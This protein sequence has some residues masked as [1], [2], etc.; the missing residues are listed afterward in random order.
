[1]LYLVSK[2]CSV[3]QHTWPHDDKQFSHEHKVTGYYY[4][5]KHQKANI[6]ITLVKQYHATR[7]GL[8]AWYCLTSVIII[9]DCVYLEGHLILSSYPTL[10]ISDLPDFLVSYK[11]FSDKIDYIRY[12]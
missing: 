2:L 11:T 3:E 7:P 8:V 4:G 5:K 9:Y 12:I 1:M 6:L 10:V